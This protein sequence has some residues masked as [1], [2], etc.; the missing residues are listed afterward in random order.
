MIAASIDENY[1]RIKADL[2]GRGLT[3]NRLIDDLLDHV[4]C[5]VE[6]Y[7]FEG[8][9]F[10]SSYKQVLESIGEKRLP[11]IQHQTLLNLDKKFQRM[12]NFTYI[13]GLTSALLT[14][15]GAFFKKMHWPG[16][17]ILVTVGIVLIVLVFL[18]LYFITNQREQVEKKNP[19]YAI[20]GY[21]TIA[22]LLAGA[23]F[24]LSHWP[25]AGVILPVGAGFLIIGFIP[26]YVVNAFQRNGS[27]KIT[28]PYITMLLVGIS[29]VMLYSN[30]NMGKNF[31]DVYV[32]EA[33]VNE[34]QL[35]QTQ[36]GTADILEWAGESCDA[37]CLMTIHAIHTDARSLQVMIF[38]MQEGMKNFLK[39]PGVPVREVEGKDSHG[40]GREVIVDTGSGH[41]FAVAALD[42]R[43]MLEEVI[44][45][46][47]SLAQI[48]DHLE[49]TG[50]VWNL[51]YGVKDV[52]DEPF[53]KTYYKLSDASKGIALAEYVAISR[54]LHP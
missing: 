21:L 28:L 49:C 20:V 27:K 45:D 19:I 51:E 33:V 8:Y 7:M 50:K 48:L 16:A 54:I 17:S 38:S 11:E 47:V 9:D 31:I 32:D 41:D 25:G 6:E 22:F 23:L 24:K 39:Q 1:D 3:Y 26:L 13:F 5:L 29:M 36:K 30:I 42:F 4:C 46:P 14:I 18:P 15:I 53:M 10:E 52:V 35:V 12:K 37:A 43:T 34:E 2:V 44:D 40:A